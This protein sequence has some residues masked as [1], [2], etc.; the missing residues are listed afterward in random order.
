MSSDKRDID[1]RKDKKNVNNLN[2]SNLAGYI[3]SHDF[4]LFEQIKLAVNYFLYIMSISRQK[5]V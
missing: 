4:L 2:A 5:S 1:L 3:Q